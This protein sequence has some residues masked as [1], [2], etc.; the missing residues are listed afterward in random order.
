MGK[1]KT[2]DKRRDPPPKK[3]KQTSS[4]TSRNTRPRSQNNVTITEEPGNHCLT[5]SRSRSRNSNTS[6]AASTSTMVPQREPVAAQ[7][8]GTGGTTSQQPPRP[9]TSGEVPIRSDLS[10]GGINRNHTTSSTISSSFPSIVPSTN[11]LQGTMER[12]RESQPSPSQYGITSRGQ[13]DDTYPQNEQT[14]HTAT[15]PQ[16]L[17]Q[18]LG[19][20]SHTYHPNQSPLHPTGD[21]LG[22]STPQNIRGKIWRGEFIDFNILVDSQDNTTRVMQDAA[23]QERANLTV[24]QVEGTWVLKPSIP[25]PKISFSPSK[26]GQT[27]FLYT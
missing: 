9:Q 6:A 4:S 7:D 8:N 23:A 14:S 25:R 24:A 10:L 5:R 11:F 1:R 20:R 22:T 17:P 15:V 13:I 2:G 21:R 16:G 18:G 27:R 26:R 19:A 3:T 12:Q